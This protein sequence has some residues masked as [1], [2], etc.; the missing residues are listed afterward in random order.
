MATLL[1]LPPDLSQLGQMLQKFA[2]DA[3]GRLPNL[4]HF[5]QCERQGL[6]SLATSYPLLPAVRDLQAIRERLPVACTNVR[7]Y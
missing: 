1:D 2:T 7:L 5:F 4:E 6:P 3:H